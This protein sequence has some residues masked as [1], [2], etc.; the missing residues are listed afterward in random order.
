MRKVNVDECYT[1]GTDGDT[2]SAHRTASKLTQRRVYSRSGK[3]M[4]AAMSIV[5]KTID[6]KNNSGEECISGNDL[7]RAEYIVIFTGTIEDHG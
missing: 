1:D 3:M 4:H 5:I 7:T 2:E 6:S